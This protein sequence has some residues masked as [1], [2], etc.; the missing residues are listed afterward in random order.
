M[1]PFWSRL[2]PSSVAGQITVFIVA[3]L[4]L[5]QVIFF[6]MVLIFRPFNLFIH[7]GSAFSGR[8]ESLIRA[9]DA[10]PPETRERAIASALTVL[11]GATVSPSGKL[12]NTEPNRP[13]EI[14]LLDA[15]GDA[16]GDPG[17]VNLV[18]NQGN[19][20][21][22]IGVALNDG[23]VLTIPLPPG[24]RLPPLMPL[25]LLVFSV[26]IILTVLSL[27]AVR[28]ITA[29]LTRFSQAAE[30]FGLSLAGEPLDDRGPAEI[31]NINAT[32]NLMRDRIR[33]LIDDRTRMLAAVSHDL[34]TPLTRLRLRVETMEDAETR[35]QALADIRS[36]ETMTQSALEYL[37]AEKRGL[38]RDH[39]DM[40][41]LLQ[42]VCDESADIGKDVTYEGPRHVA[43][44]CDPDLITRA[45]TNIVD[46]ATR[47]GEKVRVRLLANTGHAVIEIIDDGPGLSN[48]QK[49]QAFEPFYR[50]DSARALRDNA[51]FGLGLPIAKAIIEDH[52]GEVT[53]HDA[54]PS[55][56]IV[57]ITLPI[58][59]AF[60]DNQVKW[61]RK[62][63]PV[64]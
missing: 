41:S 20:K 54:A 15:L 40:S 37:R 56:L 51:G 8:V 14:L 1:K 52:G 48:E 45:V 36:I 46:N 42:T 13:G 29:P 22:R 11:P 38:K 57:R 62:I 50:G 55:G 43:V 24:S 61:P 23:R 12:D 39:V 33:R 30:R 7:P 64:D 2:A 27:W 63:G 34:R 59:P 4:V 19:E 17:R 32:F 10:E 44:V 31:R 6:S 5:A 35:E 21:T 25:A 49:Q 9:I 3:A 28:Q 16:V 47:H 26:G 60:A 53:L 58:R 18:G